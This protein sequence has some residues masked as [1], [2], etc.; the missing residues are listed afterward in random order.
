MT[1]SDVMYKLGQIKQNNLDLINSQIPPVKGDLTAAH[2]P[3]ELPPYKKPDKPNSP[4]E[5]YKSPIPSRDDRLANLSPK[6]FTPFDMGLRDEDDGI[7]NH[8]ITPSIHDAQMDHFKR[9][10]KNSGESTWD[11]SQG[12]SPMMIAKKKKKKGLTIYQEKAR[13]DA[14]KDMEN[15]IYDPNE[16]RMGGGFDILDDLFPRA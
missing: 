2:P 3:G 5:P 11:L 16:G 12:N 9:F 13:R 7:I 15:T 10:I 4:Y 14:M 6:M 1:Y 8:I